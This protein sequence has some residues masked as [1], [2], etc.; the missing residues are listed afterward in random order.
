MKPH[1]TEAADASFGALGRELDEPLDHEFM[2][3]SY[4]RLLNGIVRRERQ[5]G[6]LGPG[7]RRRGG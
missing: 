7:A 3:H 4:S 1:P 6:P 5:R 2:R